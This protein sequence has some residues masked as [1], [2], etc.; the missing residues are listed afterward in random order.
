V[1]WFTVI[2]VL[3]LSPL[4][5]VVPVPP[6][7]LVTIKFPVLGELTA[8]ERPAA[9]VGATLLTQ[10]LPSSRPLKLFVLI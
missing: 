9:T 5:L 1:P 2:P 8:P 7:V 6:P 3:P 4:P 10:L